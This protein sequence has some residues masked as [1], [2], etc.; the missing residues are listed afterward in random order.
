[1]SN[2]IVRRF[3]PVA[4]V[5]LVAFAL[6][7]A[8]IGQPLPLPRPPSA[9]DERARVLAKYAAEQDLEPADS[10]FSGSGPTEPYQVALREVLIPPLG[11]DRCQLV[12][13]PSFEPEWAIYL[14]REKGS[15]RVKLAW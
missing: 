12:V 10:V 13:V 1:M 4:F 14:A 11:Y 5:L 6:L 7:L 2:L 9:F 3:L 8:R 15:A